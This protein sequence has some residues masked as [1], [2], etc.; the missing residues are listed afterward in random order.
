MK[1]ALSHAYPRLKR[2]WSPHGSVLRR[3]GARGTP[4][5]I[6]SLRGSPGLAI[7]LEVKAVSSYEGP[8]GLE[9]LQMIELDALHNAGFIAR[10]AALVRKEKWA[11]FDPSFVRGPNYVWGMRYAAQVLTPLALLGDALAALQSSP[12]V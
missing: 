5:F 1:P 4:D 11:I 10:V 2:E 12:R 8:L 7:F 6:L 9:R 3:A